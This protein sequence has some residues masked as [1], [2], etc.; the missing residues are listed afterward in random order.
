MDWSQPFEADFCAAMEAIIIA[1]NKSK[2]AF[3]T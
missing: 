3:G 1:I 2:T